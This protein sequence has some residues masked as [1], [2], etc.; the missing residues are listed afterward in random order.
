MADTKTTALTAL[1]TAAT[2][3][4]LYIVDDP[5][6]T[7]LSKKITVDNLVK[8]GDARTATLT[9]KTIDADNNTITNI[10]LGAECTGASTDL[11]DTASIALL[12]AAQTLTNKTIDADNNTVSNIVI[13]AE[14]TG[15]S[16]ALTDTAA[17]TY[18]ADTDVS[19]NGWV[20]DEDNMASDLAT[21]VPT[22][23]SAKAYADLMDTRGLHTLWVPSGAIR[24]TSSNGCASLT[25]VETTAGRPDMQV[26]DFDATA[27]EHAQFQITWPKS[28][29][30]GTVTFQAYWTTTAVDTDGVA[31]GLQG[32]AVSDGDTIDVAY[33]TAVVVTDAGQ[34]TAEDLYVTASSAAVTIAGTPAADD[35]VYFRVFRD[36]SDA[37][38]TM[39]EDARLIGV[40]LLYTTDAS[41][42]V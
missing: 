8:A 22:Q 34:S 28:W 4:I 10:A 26:L 16:T 32:V 40:K 15:A 11:T 25:D 33:G 27:D 39:T 14:C 7:P 23:Q 18:N 20:V 1:T 3:D 17:L 6:G 13:G 36:V 24:P 5:G 21:K 30:E 38:D 9:N 35:I 19:G 31:W 42:D 12:T 29:N 37:A 41:T 2:T